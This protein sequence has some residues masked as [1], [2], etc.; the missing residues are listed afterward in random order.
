MIESQMKCATPR[1]RSR[2]KGIDVNMLCYRCAVQV[3]RC[4]QGDGRGRGRDGFS[5]ARRKEAFLHEFRSGPCN[6]TGVGGEVET[7][8][9]SSTDRVRLHSGARGAR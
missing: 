5:T 9:V 1:N 8:I 4:A 7:E 6:D 2:S 3:H